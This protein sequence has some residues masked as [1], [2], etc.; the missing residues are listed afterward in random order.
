MDANQ[1]LRKDTNWR[2]QHPGRQH[3]QSAVVTSRRDLLG[4]LAATSAGAAD[5]PTICRP[6][7][8]GLDAW[9]AEPVALKPPEDERRLRPYRYQS[10]EGC[11]ADADI[12][13]L[14]A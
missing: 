11:L 3:E 14:R 10:A 8:R 9:G 4:A 6:L 13:F 1:S 2:L 12:G 7:D 5:V